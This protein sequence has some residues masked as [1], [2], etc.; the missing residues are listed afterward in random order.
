MSDLLA[1]AGL[2]PAQ[3]LAEYWQKKPLLIRQG[4]PQLDGLL[5][6]D[7]VLALAVEAP[8]ITR[9]LTQTGAHGEHWQVKHGP[10]TKKDLRKLPPQWTLLVQAI[11]H[12]SLE[13]ADLWRLLDFL[14]RWRRD[15]VMVSYAPTGGS[16]GQH[17]DQYDVFL[18]QGYGER[19]WQLGQWCD[20][21]TALVPDQPL[22]LLAEMGEI[23]FD[24]V[25]SPGD[26]LYVPPGLAHYGVAQ[27]DCLTFSFGFRMP[28]PADLLERLADQWLAM[29]DA[30][31]PLADR[32]RKLTH[33]PYQVDTAD[34]AQMR[35]HLQALLDQPELLKQTVMSVLSEA[36][37]PEQ[38][39]EVAELTADE[40]AMHLAEGATLALEPAACVLLSP[41]HALWI[42][43][44]NAGV[45]PEPAW[46]AHLL[47]GGI[48]EANWLAALSE[49]QREVALE[50]L[51]MTLAAGAWSLSETDED[52]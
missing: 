31:Q 32:D 13:I 10:L 3:F 34:I 24:E 6:P 22:R 5:V 20:A 33:T 44:E 25:L 14:P 45:V 50:W 8:V 11:D 17:F 16:V 19:R 40:L 51:A 41:D 4:M 30:R 23:I 48:V 12:W 37:F 9:L 2:T 18:A 27:G 21:Q 49:A 28:S 39:P 38:L 35:A 47:Q 15:D 36:P 46:A 52:E 26:V 7:E 29:P 43:G 42:N 1:Q